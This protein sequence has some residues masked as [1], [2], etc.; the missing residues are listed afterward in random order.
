MSDIRHQMGDN[1]RRW[2]IGRDVVAAVLLLVALALPWNVY[3]GHGVPDSSGWLLIVQLAATALSGAGLVAG[4][5]G[6]GA[7][8]GVHQPS[9]GSVSRLRLWLSAP[10]LAGVGAVIGFAVLQVGV[11]GGSGSSPAGVGPG[12]LTGLAGA[13]LAGQ[14]MFVGRDV[15]PF[16]RWF[17]SVSVI[18]VV[19][20]VAASGAVLLNLYWRTRNVLP[21]LGDGGGSLTTLGVIL[22]YGLSAWAVVMVG[23]RWLRAPQVSSRLAVVALGAAAVLGSALVGALGVGRDI[24]A[25]HG[26]AQTTSTASVGFEAYVSWIAGAAILGPLTLR[27]VVAAGPRPA[28]WREMVRKCLSFIAFWCLSAAFLRVVDLIVVARMGFPDSPYNRSVL[29]AFD[30]VTAAGA[31]WVRSNLKGGR[32]HPAINSAMCGVLAVLTVCRVALGVGLAT[33]I[34]Y[35]SPPPWFDSSVFGNMLQQQFTCTFDVVICWL[36]IVVAAVASLV[37]SNGDRPRG[38]V[39]SPV[40]KAPRRAAAAPPSVVATPTA[41]PAAMPAAMPVGPWAAVGTAP[42]AAA[43]EPIRIAAPRSPQSGGEAQ[44]TRAL[45]E[46]T[47]RFGAGTTYTGDGRGRQ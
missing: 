16:R 43:A 26:I 10:Y 35:S 1:Q 30:V 28:D 47:Q 33:T 9:P 34:K 15:E 23:L 46:S 39:A 42:P 4:Y 36:A 37:L 2:N 14:P 11:Q 20:M 12:A 8:R 22:A 7:R 40:G 45:G 32:L 17:Q 41:Q 31:L 44:T 3:F 25:F 29:L 18:G 13:L 5:L 27:Q 6:G 24:D 38:R 21:G 19:A